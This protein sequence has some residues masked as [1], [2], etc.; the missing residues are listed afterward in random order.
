VLIF[1]IHT[2]LED[3]HE[4]VERDVP[5]REEL[6]EVA[7]HHCHQLLF[8]LIKRIISLTLLSVMLRRP[9]LLLLDF[10]WFPMFSVYN[11]SLFGTFSV[12]LSLLSL[13]YLTRP[14]LKREF[15]T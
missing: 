14:L 15:R 5:S 11:L 2:F 4:R 8:S 3:M 12:T 10:M 13:L 7:V 1:Q 6:K 9:L